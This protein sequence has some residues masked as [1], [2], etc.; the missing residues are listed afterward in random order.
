[1]GP[2]QPPEEGR[3]AC[4]GETYRA[5][6]LAALDGM[7]LFTT[8]GLWA[9]EAYAEPTEFTP[10]T[11]WRDGP[12]LWQGGGSGGGSYQGLG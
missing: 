5:V 10:D 11:L 4:T 2:S 1:M 3:C 7:N 12:T 6:A 8:L 9:E